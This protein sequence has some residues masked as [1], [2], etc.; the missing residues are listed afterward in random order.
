M[1]DEGVEYDW[2]TYDLFPAFKFDFRPVTGTLFRMGAQLSRSESPDDPCYEKK[3]HWYLR[4]LVRPFSWAAS[5]LR[6]M[7]FM[8]TDQEQT[9]TIGN[10]DPLRPA[11]GDLTEAYLSARPFGTTHQLLG[12]E[13][14]GQEQPVAYASIARAKEAECPYAANW[15]W[16]ARY[17]IC[18]NGEFNFRATPMPHWNGVTDCQVLVVEPNERLS[19]S[20]NA[21]GEEA[22]NGLKTVVTWTLTPTKGGVL[23]RV[24][25]SGFRP[26]EEANFQGAN[27]GWQ[28]YVASLE[29]VV[30]PGPRPFRDDR[31]GIRFRSVTHLGRAQKSPEEAAEVARAYADLLRCRWVND[32]GQEQPLT[33]DDILVVSPYNMRVDLLRS[34]L[35]IG[36]RVGTVDKFQGQ[37]GA[38]VLNSMATSSGDDLP[39]QIEFLYS[40]NRLNVAISRAR[41]LAVICAGLRLL[42]I[43]CS[44]IA[45]MQLVN[46]LCWAKVYADGLEKTT[47]RQQ[48]CLS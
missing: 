13:V 17:H 10:L 6:N 45:Q 35:P 7:P 47:L 27:Y 24:E 4:A 1:A 15:L 28:R 16:R 18:Q 26:E 44:T 38:V 42:E 30:G 43:A 23:V 20:W 34:V 31:P 22:A 37:E 8:N 48:R 32:K 21:S 11:I 29:R 36:A 12:Y 41:C 9:H 5:V 39:R 40:R 3:G 2:A 46:T 19:Y 25:Q 33:V 14:R